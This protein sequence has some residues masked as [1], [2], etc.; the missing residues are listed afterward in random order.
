MDTASGAS[1]PRGRTTADGDHSEES[2]GEFVHPRR[3]ASGG[4]SLERWGDR[5]VA[6]DAIATDDAD[7]QRPQ[8]TTPEDGEY[9]QDALLLRHFW[10][11]FDT[12]IILS[13]C[14]VFGIAFRMMSATWFRLELGSVF[15]EDSALGTNLPLN[16]CSCFAM[17]LLCSGREA[18]GIIHS[19]VLGGSSP[20]GSG[21]GLLDVG[22]GAYR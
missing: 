7:Q 22:R 20:Y 10:R 2:E 13:I 3:E 8:T 18:M 16:I 17:G 21:R 6:S 9:V 11:S 14:S 4:G 15:S 5:D 12:I 19:K 1:A